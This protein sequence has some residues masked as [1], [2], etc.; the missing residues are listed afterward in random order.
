MTTKDQFVVNATPDGN[1]ILVPHIKWETSKPDVVDLLPSGFTCTVVG[2]QQGVVD[3]KVTARSFTPT[4]CAEVEL[5]RTFRVCVKDHATY[6]DG[7]SLEIGE[8]T[9]KP[10]E[11]PWPTT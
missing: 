8:V 2:K 7:I 11:V 1:V 5:V 9:P 10:P 6:A 4:G 3:V